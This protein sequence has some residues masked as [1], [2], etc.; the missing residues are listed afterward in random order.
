MANIFTKYLRGKGIQNTKDDENMAPPP[1][2]AAEYG[3]PFR[4]QEVVEPPPPKTKLSFYEREGKLKSFLSAIITAWLFIDFC[5]AAVMFVCKFDILMYEGPLRFLAVILV[6]CL[7]WA[8]A[9]LRVKRVP[10]EE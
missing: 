2:D 3:Y 8:L 9:Y 10:V 7:F 5:W 6:M 1:D 4:T